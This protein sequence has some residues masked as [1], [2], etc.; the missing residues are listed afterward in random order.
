MVAVALL[1]GHLRAEDYEDE[2][3]ADPRIDALRHR[4][5]VTESSPFSKDYHDPSKRSIAN[6]IQITFE[7]GSQTELVVVEYPIGHRR[8]RAEG[9]PVL[10]EKFK[11]NAL[12]RFDASRVEGLMNAMLDQEQ[13]ER[14][15]VA[16]FM[17]SWCD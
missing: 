1:T 7:D 10:L 3:A 13:L 4:M 14:Q 5:H 2:R 8:R 11:R 9:V 16:D 12:T 17:L 6:A 15:S